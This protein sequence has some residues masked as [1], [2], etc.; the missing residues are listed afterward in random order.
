MTLWRQSS[1]LLSNKKNKQLGDGC[2]EAKHCKT[3]HVDRAPSELLLTRQP[4]RED[5]HPLLHLVLLICTPLNLDL[6]ISFRISYLL[7]T[8]FSFQNFKVL[9]FTVS[10]L[11]FWPLLFMFINVCLYSSQTS[12]HLDNFL[13]DSEPKIAWLSCT[14]SGLGPLKTELVEPWAGLHSGHFN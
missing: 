3:S 8:Y 5:G 4:D 14:R 13:H 12:S 10:A 1:Y 6:H 2:Y 9:I 7:L 11:P